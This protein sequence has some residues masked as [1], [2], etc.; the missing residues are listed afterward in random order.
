M[1]HFSQEPA[2][3]NC[4]G[5]TPSKQVEQ[6]HVTGEKC[7]WINGQ[8]PHFSDLQYR[9]LP[10]KKQYP[11]ISFLFSSPS[12]EVGE[13][14][15]S[16]KSL[17]KRSVSEGVYRR[18]FIEILQGMTKDRKEAFQEKEEKYS[19]NYFHWSSFPQPPIAESILDSQESKVLHWSLLCGCS[20]CFL[21]EP[22]FVLVTSSVLLLLSLF[23][24]ITLQRYKAYFTVH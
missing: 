22:L 21:S 12:I 20:F 24:I 4:L 5:I 1:P 19:P 11:P 16:P 17:I 14:F 18:L 2:S 13:L 7:S 3:Q 15:G 23:N 10:N 6:R 9:F 8:L